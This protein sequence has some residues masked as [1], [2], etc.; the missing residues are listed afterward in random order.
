M[1]T[2][3]KPEEPR[4]FLPV[5]DDEPSAAAFLSTGIVASTDARMALVV[6]VICE[7]SGVIVIDVATA[8]RAL[9]P[10][11]ASHLE[12]LQALIADIRGYAAQRINGQSFDDWI[13]VSLPIKRE[14]E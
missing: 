7:D 13:R 3:D 1:S 5:D 2:D 10:S 4:P 12:R 8:E 9:P 6:A 11:C 14:G